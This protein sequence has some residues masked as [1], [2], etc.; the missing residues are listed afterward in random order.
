[1]AGWLARSQASTCAASSAASSAARGPKPTLPSVSGPT[2]SVL[3]G[4]FGG[5][6]TGEHGQPARVQDPQGGVPV[7]AP[8]R[9]IGEPRRRGGGRPTVLGRGG[10]RRHHV[11][12]PGEPRGSP[13][14]R[15]GPGPISPA[16][17]HPACTLVGCGTEGPE[18]GSAS[19]PASDLRTAGPDAIRQHERQPGL[20]HHQALGT[21]QAA[22]HP[23]E[24]AGRERPAGPGPPRS[25]RD[26]R[27]RMPPPPGVP[28]TSSG[29]TIRAPGAACSSQ[30]PAR[31]LT[32]TVAMMRS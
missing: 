28:R 32:P 8:Q 4:R 20:Q 6:S 16:V 22:A 3:G 17:W 29:T 24:P 25:R 10:V 9:G 11:V 21:G 30:G 7:P 27:V 31:S 18:S 1:M 15:T 5:P 26:R 23:H 19:T 2:G 13:A 14:A 12:E